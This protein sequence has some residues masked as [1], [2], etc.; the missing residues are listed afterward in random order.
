MPFMLY[1]HCA[2]DAVL[3]HAQD[4]VLAMTG[5]GGVAPAP[6][7]LLTGAGGALPLLVAA[8]ALLL[9][10]AAAPPL[11]DASLPG[12]PCKACGACI[13]GCLLTITSLCCKLIHEFQRQIRE[14]AHQLGF[15]FTLSH[16][17]GSAIDQRAQPLADHCLLFGHALQAV[18][19]LET[20]KQMPACQHAVDV[21]SVHI[22]V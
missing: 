5:P 7:G 22:I 8:A 17:A 1:L 13:L 18:G 12:K 6:T 16:A 4:A 9:A 21:P 14:P 19:D 3:H 2:C 11:S 10:A 15:Q 20:V